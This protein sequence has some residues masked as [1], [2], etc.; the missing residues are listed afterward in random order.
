MALELL[1]ED[2]QKDTLNPE[3]WVRFSKASLIFY[4]SDNA[5]TSIEKAID[6]DPDEAKYYFEKGLL[7][8]SL[9]E[10]DIALNAL[11]KA[12]NIRKAGKYFYLKGIVNQRL[13]NDEDARSDYNL[14]IKHGFS[15]P[16][17]YN[18]LAILQLENREYSK[19][20]DNINKAIE[21]NPAYSQ[22]YS[23]KSKILFFQLK[24]DLACQAKS[25]ALEF[26]YLDAFNIPDSVCAGS[27]QI[28]LQFA[29]ENICNELFLG[30]RCFSI[31]QTYRK[32]IFIRKLFF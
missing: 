15:T 26:G 21:Q 12:V 23:A 11:E 25:K 19:A 9:D 1:N 7:Y 4:D 2:F 29:A 17:I 31:F 32:K 14:A 27:E 13:E 5:K 16:E 18:N 30:D 8:N 3:Y 28:K 24:I 6:L 20:L 10:L 22:A